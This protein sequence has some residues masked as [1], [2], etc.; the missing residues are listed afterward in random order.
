[1]AMKFYMLLDLLDE[2]VSVSTPVGD[3]GAAKRFYRSCTISLTN[4]VTLVN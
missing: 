1:M 2:P 4:I 3:S